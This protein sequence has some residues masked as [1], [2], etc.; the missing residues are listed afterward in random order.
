MR[1][2]LDFTPVLAPAAGRTASSSVTSLRTITLLLTLG[3]LPL[4]T[5]DHCHG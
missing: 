1:R 3:S 5:R 4:P 2:A